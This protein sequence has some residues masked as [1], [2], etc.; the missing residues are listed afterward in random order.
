MKACPVCGG[1]V[2]RRSLRAVFCSDRCKTRDFRARVAR[3]ADG[4]SGPV[5]T[6]RTQPWPGVTV[7]AAL[8]Q[9]VLG[10]VVQDPKTGQ[11]RTVKT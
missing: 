5:G 4:V 3:R 7:T 6:A 1:Q 10:F 9:R 8:G 11:M 2:I